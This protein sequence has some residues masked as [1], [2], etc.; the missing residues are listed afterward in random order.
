MKVPNYF[1]SSIFNSTET[2]Y[3]KSACLYLVRAIDNFN[4]FRL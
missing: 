3:E 1:S 2:Y 4:G